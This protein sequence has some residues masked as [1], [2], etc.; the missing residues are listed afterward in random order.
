VICGWRCTPGAAVGAAAGT[1]LDDDED[2]GRA[3]I[4]QAGASRKILACN[5]A[6]RDA[7][8]R[9]GLALNTAWALMPGLVV[10]EFDEAAQS[11]HL[12][13]LTL[14]ALTAQG[15]SFVCAVAPVP[16]AALLLARAGISSIVREPAHLD[17]VLAPIPLSRLMLDERVTKGLQ[18]SGV[19]T[20]GALRA[21]RCC[22]GWISGGR[23]SGSTFACSVSVSPPPPANCFELAVH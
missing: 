2:T 17:A 11:E 15:V 4:V 1:G 3:V 5:D 21:A 16:S 9:A 14:L 10:T 20:L 18:R 19:R 22:S 8:V 7:G 12:E 13:Q 23:G 6:A